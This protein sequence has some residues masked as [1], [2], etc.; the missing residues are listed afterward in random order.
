[1][2][3]WVVTLPLQP[4]QSAAQTAS[5]SP[6]F[7]LTH[8]FPSPSALFARLLFTTPPATS[9]PSST[10]KLFAVTTGVAFHGTLTGRV[11]S[12]L[13]A[14]DFVVDSLPG[15]FSSVQVQVRTDAQTGF[16][17][18]SGV[19]GLNVG[20]KASLSCFLLKTTVD[21]V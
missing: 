6:V 4:V 21:P 13:N 12:I 3:A 14:T 7:H 15:N 17:G 16:L 10:Y 1:M 19:A 11:K 9:F 20:D 2:L 18:I 5:F 8:L